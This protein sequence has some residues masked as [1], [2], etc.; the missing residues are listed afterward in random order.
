MDFSFCDQT[1]FCQEQQFLKNIFEIS[2]HNFIPQTG[3]F[4][5]SRKMS[6]D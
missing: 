6:T 2:Y 5:K 1:N 3:V 4:P